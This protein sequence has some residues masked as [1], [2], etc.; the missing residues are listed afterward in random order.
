MKKHLAILLSLLCVVVLFCSC[1][2]NKKDGN[3]ESQNNPSLNLLDCGFEFGMTKD[4]INKIGRKV[5]KS[6]N[7]DVDSSLFKDGIDRDRIIEGAS[8]DLFPYKTNYYFDEEDRLYCIDFWV[9]AVEL[10]DAEIIIN[11]ITSIYGKK[12]EYNYKE[13]DKETEYKTISTFTY[14]DK[15]IQVYIMYDYSYLMNSGTLEFYIIAP[16]YEV[17]EKQLLN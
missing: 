15:S 11:N 6:D 9:P 16:G 2:D 3:K 8:K 5:T 4:E 7:F 12:D 17:P 14:K 13:T 1:D 10:N